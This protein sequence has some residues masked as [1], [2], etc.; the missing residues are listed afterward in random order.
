LSSPV[1]IVVVD[2]VMGGGGE[3]LAL[4]KGFLVFFG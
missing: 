1:V 2:V 3:S 4:G